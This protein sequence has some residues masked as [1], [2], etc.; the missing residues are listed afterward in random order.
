MITA[1]PHFLVKRP[2]QAIMLEN[3][4][5]YTLTGKTIATTPSV[6]YFGN[7]SDYFRDSRTP[8]IA[9][10]DYS[11]TPSTILQAKQA[12]ALARYAGADRDAADELNEGQTLLDDAE[13]SWKAGRDQESVDITARKAISTLVKAE[14]TA[15]VRKD[16]RD[17][18]NEKISNDAEIRKAEDKFVDAQN[19]IADLKAEL[20]S[21]TRSRELAERDATNYAGQIKDLRQENGQL[22][23]E[24]A[25]T[26][27][28]AETAKTRLTALEGE[29]ESIK[30]QRD[31]EAKIA[32]LNASQSALILNLK[33]F[34]AVTTN[35]RGIVLTLPETFWA[36]SRSADFA[37]N[38]DAKLTSLAD[39]FV[40]NPDYRI[41]IESHTDNKGTPEEL[42]TLTQQRSQAIAD[43]IAGLGVSSSRMQAKGMGASLPVAPNTTVANRAK[44]RRVQ[45]VLSAS[46]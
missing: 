19:Q 31:R 28:D 12:L 45:I 4:N 33:R 40:N 36:N 18:R 30:Q 39:I 7:S 24:L 27:I 32:S 5:P 44:N 29:N 9:E 25:R 20:A 2:S 35:E 26:K 34:G 21:E 13:N 8:E 15:I 3:L 1:E 37:P 6:Q 38:A 46:L 41:A 14:D 43:R 16:A 23:E 22:R 42:Q 17:K 10:T 11:K